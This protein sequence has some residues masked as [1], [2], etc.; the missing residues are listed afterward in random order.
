MAQSR[1]NGGEG[2]SKRHVSPPDGSA[3]PGE[4]AATRRSSPRRP[5][6][7]PADLPQPPPR[8]NAP[9]VRTPPGVPAVPS[10][11]G[12]RPVRIPAAGGPT[13][14][15]AP[16]ASDSTRRSRDTEAATGAAALG[17]RATGEARR[18][19]GEADAGTGIGPKRDGGRRERHAGGTA[20][21]PGSGGQMEAP[22]LGA[23]LRVPAGSLSGPGRPNPGRP[24]WK[25][26]RAEAG[27]AQKPDR[28]RSRT[29]PGT[30]PAQEPDRPRN[31]TGPGTGPAQEPDRP[32]NR[33]GP[34]TGL[35]QEPD[36]A[37]NR[38]GPA[39]SGGRTRHGR[40]WRP[41]G[42]EADGAWRSS[43]THPR[44]RGPMMPPTAKATSARLERTADSGQRAMAVPLRARREPCSRTPRPA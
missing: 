27:P 4:A 23:G 29:G 18:V 25:L 5:P 26:D 41:A 39:L 42:G 36:W 22:R 31:R 21:G 8:A 6:T 19:R 28:P 34:G 38:T 32:R 1:R 24:V 30:G 3:R 16:S 37:R 35:G 40:A 13:A 9:A 20:D 33:T 10:A 2:H 15:A 14:R 11:M 17:R 44:Q 43:R 7:V 12:R